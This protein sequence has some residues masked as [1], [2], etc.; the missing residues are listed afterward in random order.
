MS[1]DEISIALGIPDGTVKAR[2]IR[3]REEI[4]TLL[5][6]KGHLYCYKLKSLLGTEE[7]KQS[8]GQY[9]NSGLEKKLKDTVQIMVESAT[10]PPVEES[11]SRFEQKRLAQ[12]SLLEQ[13]HISKGR[14]LLSLQLAA[15]A[16]IIILLA[17][18]FLFYSR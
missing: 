12:Q 11:W 1:V 4:K 17:G 9:S 5:D 7:V 13:P 10:P 8:S 3:A 2:L 18:V 6:S 15:A 14:D 16:G